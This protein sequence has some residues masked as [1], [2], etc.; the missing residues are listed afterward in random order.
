MSTKKPAYINIRRRSMVRLSELHRKGIALSTIPAKML[1]RELDVKA[2]T[3][4]TLEEC[5]VFAMHLLTM[6]LCARLIAW[7]D[8]EHDYPE[9]PWVPPIITDDDI[10]E[11]EG[12]DYDWSVLDQHRGDET[13]S[14]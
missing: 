1:F 10:D 8:M 13:A 5:Q 4:W 14:T 9:E 12:G 3:E 11:L 6:D 7:H 2:H